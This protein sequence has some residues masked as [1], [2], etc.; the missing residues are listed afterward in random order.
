FGGPGGS[1]VGLATN[2]AVQAE[3]K[4]KADQKTKI[5]TL[6]DAL[7]EQRRQLFSQMNPNQGQGQNQG[8]GRRR[9]RDANTN[10]AAPDQ[11]APGGGGG[12]FGGGG[13]GFGG[14]GFGGG[15]FGGGGFG[16]G[17][18]QRNGGGDAGNFPG[19]PPDPERAQRFAMMREAMDELQQSGESGLAR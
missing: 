14:G 18:G 12:G 16:G 6:A 7:N 19:G 8:G 13:G 10:G 15:G 5:Q 4:L 2:P 11:N 3:L 9:N 1:I 17:Q